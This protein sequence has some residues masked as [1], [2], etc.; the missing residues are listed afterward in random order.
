MLAV[1]E[2][3]EEES[4]C[5]S[6][7]GCYRVSLLVTDI[8]GAVAIIASAIIANTPTLLTSQSIWTNVWDPVLAPFSC[9]D[10]D[11][12]DVTDNDC[13]SSNEVQKLA[14]Q[15]RKLLPNNSVDPFSYDTT[16][17]KITGGIF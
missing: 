10:D 14:S 17:K 5:A 6:S 15:E 16:Y 1:I 12:D 8:L 4:L 13:L 11:D 9:R 7:R 2:Q 3:T